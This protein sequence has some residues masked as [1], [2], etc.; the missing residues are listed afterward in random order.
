[1]RS[2]K[3]IIIFWKIIYITKPYSIII[4]IE[5]RKIFFKKYLAKCPNIIR[6]FL[7]NPYNTILNLTILKF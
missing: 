6:I 2:G 5:N 1:M 7:T 3:I 4:P